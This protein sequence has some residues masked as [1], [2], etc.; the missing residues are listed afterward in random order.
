V[1]HDDLGDL[2]GL[3]RRIH[4]ADEVDERIAALDTG[5]KDALE[6]PQSSRQIEAGRGHCQIPRAS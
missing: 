4:L 1:L 5:A 3:E 2:G 6:C